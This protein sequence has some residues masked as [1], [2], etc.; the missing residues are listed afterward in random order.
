MGVRVP[1]LFPGCLS[2][3]FQVV[4][5]LFP[6]CFQVVSRL[7]C[8]CQEKSGEGG[9]LETPRHGCHALGW[10]QPGLPAALGWGRY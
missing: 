1:R 8:P 10:G 4:S 9:G 3:C 5:R 7:F 6:G 2:G